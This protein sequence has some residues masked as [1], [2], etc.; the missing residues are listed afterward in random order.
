MGDEAL[1]QGLVDAAVRRRG[2]R[3]N[4][5]DPRHRPVAQQGGDDGA[6]GDLPLLAG[7]FSFVPFWRP[8]SLSIDVSG[9]SAYG[10]GFEGTVVDV[11][12]WDA[13][14]TKAFSCHASAR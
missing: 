5:R 10:P 7:N 14:T 13:A 4:L 11:N 1:E 9:L 6:R 2:A 3:R 12:E 8:T